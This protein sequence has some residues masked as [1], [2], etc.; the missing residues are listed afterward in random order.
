MADPPVANEVVAQKLSARQLDA[1]LTSYAVRR[2]VGKGA[3]GIVFEAQQGGLGRRVAIKVLPPNLALRDRTVKR[4]LR[5][6]EAMGRL[7]HANVVDIYEVGSESD[8]LHYFAMQYVE[9]PPL[10]VVLRAGP[11]AIAD[12]VRIGIQVSDALAHAHARGVMH[13]DIKPSNLLRSD[14]SVMLTDFGLARPLDSEETG[15]MTESGDLVGTPLY[16][17]PE[18]ISGDTAV[19]DGRSDVWGLGVTLYELLIQKPPFTGSSATQIL[20]KILHKDPPLL[21]RQRDDV[22]PELEAVILKCLEKDPT[23]RYSGAAALHEDLC[24]IRD[25]QPVSASTPRFFDPALRWMRR[26]PVQ[27]GVGTF[28]VLA[29]TALTVFGSIQF[30]DAR[31]SKAEGEHQR[32]RADE[33]EGAS[34]IVQARFQLLTAQND[35][36]TAVLAERKAREERRLKDARV[37]AREKANAIERMN[38]LLETF[39]M[40]THP[41]IATEALKAIAKCLQVEGQGDQGV[42]MLEKTQFGDS[43]EATLKVQAAFFTGLGQLETALGFH[44]DRIALNPQSVDAHLDAGTLRRLIGEQALNQGDADGA[45]YMIEQARADLN[46][47]LNLAPAEG[48]D[49]VKARILTERAQCALALGEADAANKDLE[50]ALQLDPTLALARSLLEQ[51]TE[52]QTGP[53]P[54]AT[55]LRGGKMLEQVFPGLLDVSPS[56]LEAAGD[57]IRTLVDGALDMIG[58]TRQTNEPAEAEQAPADGDPPTESSAGGE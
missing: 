35:F 10:D 18:Q 24:A 29:V 44:D 15:T 19:I 13:R 23:R 9:G 51:P 12:V 40:E 22:P 16:M 56:D 27:T 3:M 53:S 41:E 21:R 8:T 50:N 46:E 38:Q 33:A 11:M 48:A 37:H 49:R 26:N 17:S 39:P 2:E 14:D 25:G 45:R 58:S 32:V 54:L 20:N 55:M 1:E 28:A 4:F 43:E 34:E 47:A 7:S 36:T 42:A 52:D 5:E 31:E 57:G 6:A 30:K